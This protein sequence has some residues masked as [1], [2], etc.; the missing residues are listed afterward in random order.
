MPTKTILPLLLLLLLGFNVKG[1]ET[2]LH[3][4]FDHE[5]KL[6]LDDIL[7]LRLD[8]AQ[9]AIDQKKQAGSKNLSLHYLEDYIDFF[10]AFV[11]GTYTQQVFGHYEDKMQQRLALIKQGDMS[12]PYYNYLQGDIYLRWGM[13]YALYGENMSALGQI[14]R[15]TTL[16]ER[17]K[18]N[19]P[20]F[21]ANK[22]ALGIL[23][24]LVGAIP[25]QYQWGVSLL[26]LKGTTKQGLKELKTVL[27]YGIKNEDFAFRNEVPLLYG[28]LLLYMGHHEDSSWDLLAPYQLEKSQNPLAASIL[29]KRY[30]KK[31]KNQLA[32]EVLAYNTQQKGDYHFAYLDFLKGLTKLYQLNTDAKYDFNLFLANY[33]GDHHVKEAYQKLAWNG[34]L[35]ENTIA[36]KNYLSIASSQGTGYDY[37]D[38]AAKKE[39][40]NAQNGYLPHKV[41]LEARLLFDG[42]YYTKAGELLNRYSDQQFSTKEY[43]LEYIYRKARVAHLLSQSSKAIK[44]YKKVYEDGSGESFYYAC[45]AALQLGML[46]ETMNERDKA[47]TAYKLC[48]KENPSQYRN[49]LHSKAKKYLKALE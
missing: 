46:Y 47:H 9:R 10:K 42:G 34:I 8:K 37:A 25:S 33:K 39:A 23:Y 19:H 6:I 3:Y 1:Q 20:T 13:I 21:I 29:A 28:I 27:D 15:A 14:K 36:Y 40:E 5:I 17:N 45:S 32:A 41:L 30:L 31:G 12:D 16:L 2:K 26:G 18:Q 22:K 4:K 38:K 48:L 43:Q 44:N 7:L 49:S 35:Q 24:S 11:D